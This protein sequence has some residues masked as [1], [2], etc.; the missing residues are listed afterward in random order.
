MVDGSSRTQY[1]VDIIM[2]VYNNEDSIF[3]SIKSLFYQDF[4]GVI[5]VIAVDDGSDDSSS[6]EL[7][8]VKKE[9][10]RDGFEIISIYS[11]NQGEASALNK[12]LD[13]IMNKTELP[14]YIGLVEADV[15]VE[16]NWT[17]LL[18]TELS[19]EEYYGAG[20]MLLPWEGLNPVARVTGY[21]VEYRM[22]KEGK[23]V[24][25]LTSANVIYKRK[26]FDEFGRFDEGLKNAAL[27]NDFNFRIVAAGK[28]LVRSFEAR[29]YHKYKTRVLPFLKRQYYYAKY[30]PFLKYSSSYKGDNLIKVGVF[31][32]LCFALSLLS[33][34]SIAFSPALIWLILLP[35]LL[36]V[37][38]VAVNCIP[39]KEIRKR[40]KDRIIFLY[41]FL[42]SMRAF[43]GLL[44]YCVGVILFVVR[45]K[46][47]RRKH[48]TVETG[49]V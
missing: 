14:D 45:N 27:D 34:I 40:H 13:F 10:K 4:E 23:F 38:N 49:R 9:F 18:I 26:V 35:F 46:L 37:L 8:L 7:E 21:D 25:H 44:G 15:K 11:D 6:I 20:G 47:C 43:A 5:K 33:L 24:P 36:L 12:G 16:P 19:G 30:R 3:E 48:L 31:L 17:S 2:P 42:M 32:S 41:P 22:L 29:A 39:L 28:K 1:K